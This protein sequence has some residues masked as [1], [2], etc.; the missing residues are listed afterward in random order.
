VDLGVS[1]RA[2]LGDAMAV[3]GGIAAAVYT[4]LGERAR[5]HIST[6]SYTAVCYGV[7]AVVLVAACLVAGAPLGGYPRL[8][9]LAILGMTVG[10]QLLGHSVFNFTLRRISATTISVLILLEVPGAALIG[11]LWLGQIPRLAALPGLVVLVAGVVIVVLA[12]RRQKAP[13]EAPVAV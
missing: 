6:V 12:G 1:S 10:P 2:V 7:C 4:A 5:V 8:T 3:G 9:W 13:V 11:W